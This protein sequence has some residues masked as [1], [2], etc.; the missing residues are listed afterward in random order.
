MCGLLLLFPGQGSQAVG[1]GR[2]L[3]ETFSVA[4]ETFRE[5]EDLLGWDLRGLCLRGPI[6]L[7]TRTLPWGWAT[8]I[9][10]APFSVTQVMGVIRYA[11]RSNS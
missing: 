3:W 1:M 8:V 2:H 10:V 6:D 9:V 5:A 4:R 11:P 7:L